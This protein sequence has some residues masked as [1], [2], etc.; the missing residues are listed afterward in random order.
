MI[1][2]RNMDRVSLVCHAT[3]C[4][5]FAMF[6]NPKYRGPNFKWSQ[7]PEMMKAHC[8]DQVFMA[9]IRGRDQQA[10]FEHAEETGYQIAKKMV[11]DAG[12]E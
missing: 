11:E 2:N 10:I 5:M 9:N 6:C 12:F 3:V 8:T 4:H 1:S 7:F